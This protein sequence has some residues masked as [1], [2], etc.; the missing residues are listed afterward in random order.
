[1]RRIVRMWVRIRRRREMGI[2]IG[3]RMM[4]TMNTV[5]FTILYRKSLREAGKGE[6]REEGWWW[7]GSGAWVWYGMVAEIKHGGVTSG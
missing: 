1:M 2:R 5:G 4:M 6:T 3:M 7:W